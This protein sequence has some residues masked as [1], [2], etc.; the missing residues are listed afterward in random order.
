MKYLLNRFKEPSTW[1]GV[2]LLLTVFGVN[3][4]PELWGAITTVG[5]SAVGAIGVLAPD[6]K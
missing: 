2:C 5:I 3:I 4:Q 6:G 1:R